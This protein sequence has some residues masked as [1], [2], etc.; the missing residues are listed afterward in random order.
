[1]PLQ[2]RF[3]SGARKS[4]AKPA[5]WGLKALSSD[6][7]HAHKKSRGVQGFATVMSNP[8]A[9][10]AGALSVGLAIGE[11][12]K[13]GVRLD[14]RRKSH[15]CT[16]PYKYWEGWSLDYSFSLR[17]MLSKGIKFLISSSSGVAF[18]ANFQPVAGGR[19]VTRR[20]LRD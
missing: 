2:Q 7:N 1:M 11:R 6:R 17:I 20:P 3:C 4:G 19:C 5:A 14:Q 9:T 10:Q 13:V 12:Q 8:G 18:I 15:T 16:V